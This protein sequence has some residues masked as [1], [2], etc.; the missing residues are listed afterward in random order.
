MSD[1]RIK[2][3]ASNRRARHDYDLTETMEAGLVL[4]GSEVKVLR[5]GKCTLSAAHVRV[6]AGE[7]WLVGATIPEYPFANRFNHEPDR[8]RKLLLHKRQVERLHR[9]LRERGTSCVVTRVYFKG[10]RVKVE[11]AVARGKKLHDK[12]Q[13]LKSKQAKREMRRNR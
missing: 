4:L 8:D 12:R 5:D 6:I 1:A 3:I 13:A 9:E 2:I 11:I 10:A 7:A